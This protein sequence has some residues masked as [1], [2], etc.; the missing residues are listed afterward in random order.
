MNAPR[1]PDGPPVRDG[2]PYS[3]I[4]HLAENVVPF[5]AMA[6][7]LREQGLSAPEIYHADLEQGLL[8]LE[9]LGDE[10]VVAGDPP[11]P[12]AGALRGRGRRAAGAARTVGCR[13]RCRSRRMSN[14]RS[15]PT[16]WT[17]S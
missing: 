3:A 9:D 13:M 8:L 17:R 15:R 4:A 11:A 14:I 1:R 7:G 2:K 12:I 5:V 10:R 16:T 6:K